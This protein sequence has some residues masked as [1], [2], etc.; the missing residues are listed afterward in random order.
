MR[1]TRTLKNKTSFTYRGNCAFHC[2]NFSLRDSSSMGHTRQDVTRSAT[3]RVMRLGRTL[4]S[5]KTHGTSGRATWGHRSAKMCGSHQA[6]TSNRTAVVASTWAPK[7]NTYPSVK[8]V[9]NE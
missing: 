1:Y 6:K 4:F 7:T 9:K 3:K 5:R 8:D 2:K